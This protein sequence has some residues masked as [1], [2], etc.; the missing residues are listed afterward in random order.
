MQEYADNIFNN[1]ENFKSSNH[2]IKEN[3][4]IQIS[5]NMNAM[6]RKF[7][8]EQDIIFVN[9]TCNKLANF[10]FENKFV[11]LARVCADWKKEIIQKEH[12]IKGI[13]DEQP[14]KNSDN[15]ALFMQVVNYIKSIEKELAKSGIIDVEQMEIYGI[16]LN[17]LDATLRRG[18][19][20]N[21]TQQQVNYLLNDVLRLKGV[22]QNNMNQ[23]DDILGAAGISR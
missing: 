8:T 1:L 11:G 9:D 12:Q 6:I 13:V 5:M 19:T 2:K 17:Q 3:A 23:I 20:G 21:L 4:S 14:Q 10:A 22:Y 7:T 18:N 15:N 16:A